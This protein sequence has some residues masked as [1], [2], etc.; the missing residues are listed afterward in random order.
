LPDDVVEQ[1]PRH[2]HD[3]EERLPGRQPTLLS[4]PGEV[5]GVDGNRTPGDQVGAD[6]GEKLLERQ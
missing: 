5:P 2:R 6:A 4:Q 1:R 3:L